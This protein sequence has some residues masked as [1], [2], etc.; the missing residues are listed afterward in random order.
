MLQIVVGILLLYFGAEALV[1]GS[2]NLSIRAGISPLVVGLTVVAFGTS[3]PELTVSLTASLQGMGAVSFGN[4]IGSNVFNIVVILALSSI[5]HPLSIHVNL[6][7]RD[8]PIMIGISLIGFGLIGF[9][10]VP[11]WVGFLLLL[12]LGGYIIFTLRLARKES[13]EN[14]KLFDVTPKPEGPLWRDIVFVIAGLGVLV[15]G[16]EMFVAGAVGIAAKLGIS[17]AVIGLTIIAAGTSLP[18]LATSI[19]A[20]LKRQTDIAVGNIVGSNIFN[21]LLILGSTAAVRP[22]DTTGISFIDG[23][24]MLGSSII[25]LPLAFTDRSISRIEGLVLFSIYGGYLYWLWP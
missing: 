20:A 2:T 7:K 25:L 12:L 10:L 4:V 22:I 6:L 13:K 9:D 17:E 21:I 19:V 14:T 11:R 16:A 18:E 23:A 15:W 5:I 1:R 8:I 24:F 3:A